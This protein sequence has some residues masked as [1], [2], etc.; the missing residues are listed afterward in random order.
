MPMHRCFAV[1]LPMLLLGLGTTAL[2][3]RAPT[4]TERREIASAAR[5]A[6]ET[7]GVRGKF[8]VRSVRVSSADRRWAKALL[9][10]KPAY[11]GRL[12]VATAVF[13]RSD[14]RWRLRNLGTADV[15]CVIHDA[16]VRANL[17]L[18]C[19]SARAAAAT[20][21]ACK[22]VHTHGRTASKVRTNVNCTKARRLLLRWLR[23][24]TLPRDQ[25]G[26]FCAGR[27]TVTCGAGNGGSAPFIRFRYRR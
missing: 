5:R 12:D 1:L 3:S 9:R 8:L 25:L 18:D 15:G 11:R 19:S 22:P 14:G 10:P 27:P 2:A 4:K 20:V 6:P 13:H 23:R 26:W 17:G 21:R 7:R 24:G 16:A